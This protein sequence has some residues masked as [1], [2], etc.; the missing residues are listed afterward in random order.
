MP[1]VCYKV[2][3]LDGMGFSDIVVAL[4][5]P[6]R[7]CPYSLCC[8][9]E[10]PPRGRV[11]VLKGA[12]WL[13]MEVQVV[14]LGIQYHRHSLDVG[15]PWPSLKHNKGLISQLLVCETSLP[16]NIFH[17]TASDFV[18]RKQCHSLGTYLRTASVEKFRAKLFDKVTR[19][20]ITT[21]LKI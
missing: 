16:R 17:N 13:R 15:Q 8:D 19:S 1:A 10:P 21:I 7:Y 3:L 12:R 14:T 6:G 9:Y 20:Y 5:V 18:R 11:G 2:W 4:F